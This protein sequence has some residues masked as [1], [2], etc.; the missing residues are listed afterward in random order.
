MIDYLRRSWA[1]VDL[2]RVGHNVQSLRGI[3][4]AGTKI[5]GVVKADAYGHGDQFI[6]EQLLG[7]GVD[8]F[9]VSNLEEAVSL[10]ERGISLPVLIFGVTPPEY[11]KTLAEHN[12]TATVH[13]LAYAKALDAAAK[14]ADV[15]V[16]A[17]IKLDTGMSR[18]GFVM[19]DGYFA[20]S[21]EEAAACCALGRLRIPGIYTHFAVADEPGGDSAAFTRS[22]FALF[23]RAVAALEGRGLRFALTHCCNSAAS[24]CY[25]EMH[26]DMVRPGILLYGLNPS[27]DLA[28][29]LDLQP[30]MGL[31]SCVAMVKEIDEG[32][33]VSYGRIYTAHR[34][35]KVATVP[36]G[37]ADG[38]ERELSNKARMLVR[39]RI[40]NVIGRICM[41][42]LMLD[43]THIEGVREGDL[44]TIVGPDG[45]HTL[46]FDEMAELSGTINYEKVCLIGKRVPRV[47][48]R[49]GEEIGVVDYIRRQR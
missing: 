4:S 6:T 1:V 47:Y 48:R 22:Q 10:R 40:A 31:Y 30:V 15:T 41:D 42:Q 35:M 28:G 18:L 26:L 14:K 17:H 27:R 9:G 39:G 3:L 24:I 2:D 12:L 25:P 16:E 44:V 21:V 8:W 49:G 5:M 19:T 23:Q 36:I 32:T 33:F 45:G 37:Y 20:P 46:T 11:A 34:R 13:T 43:V 38:Y 7:L 29:R